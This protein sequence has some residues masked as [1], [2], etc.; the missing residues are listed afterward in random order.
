MEL[1]AP[2]GGPEQ[3]QYAIHFGADA[4]YL[5]TERFGMRRAAD[6]FTLE[7]LPAAIASAHARGVRVH[8]AV[9]TIMRNAD[10]P[11]LPAYFEALAAAGADAFIISDLGALALARRHAPQVD[12]HLSTQASC[13]NWQAAC[14]YHELGAKRIVVARELSLAEIAELRANTPATLELE[15]F[16][17]GAMCMSYSGRC[18]ISDALNGRPAN[19]GHCTQPCR[20]K[21]AL[22]EQTRPGEFFP[23]EEDE[24][25]SYLLSSFDMNMLAHLDALAEAGV[26]SIKIEGRNKGTYYVAAV[27]NAY[28][29]VL[30]GA[31][32][33]E[34]EAELNATSHRPFSTGF[35]FGTPGQNIA[36]HP[37]YTQ[38]RQLAAGVEDAH[39]VGESGLWEAKVTLRNKFSEGDTLEVLSPGQPIKRLQVKNLRRLVYD[40]IEETT[41]VANRTKEPY[42]FTCETPLFPQD[43][44]RTLDER[45]TL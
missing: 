26:D 1:L 16:V 15:A 28:R 22:V 21:Y 13:S 23:I 33:A 8:V 25:G 9:N 35:Y 4:V 44:L 38:T 12:V 3:L 27:V 40:S 39:K 7:A 17:H 18:I 41:Q 34:W 45:I 36:H 5:A 11:Q 43:I 10:V 31:P 2:A 37:D 42:L 32:L 20:W 24:R 14:A 30:S 6:N 19:Q 29:Q